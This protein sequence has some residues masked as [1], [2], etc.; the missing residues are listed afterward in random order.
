VQHRLR[1]PD[2]LQLACALETGAA[3]LITHDR[4]FKRVTALPV[5]DGG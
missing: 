2:A 1:L 4:D 3:A 5:L